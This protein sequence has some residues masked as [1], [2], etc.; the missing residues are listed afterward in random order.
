MS[1]DRPAA[2]SIWRP[3]PSAF[4]VQMPPPSPVHWNTMEGRPAP[5]PPA[6]ELDA[7]LA[8]VAPE[9]S[10]PVALLAAPLEAPP[11]PAPAA[12]AALDA[13]AGFPAPEPQPGTDPTNI[14]AI[15]L[16]PIH[17]YPRA[18]VILL[19]PTLSA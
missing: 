1:G 18:M 11:A 15:T 17:Q 2:R 14:A 16:T 6:P 3:V 7:L 12:A 13:A 4:I 5:P 19:R 9:L 8:V 10:T